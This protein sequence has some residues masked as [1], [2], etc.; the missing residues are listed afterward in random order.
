[1]GHDCA[2]V[3]YVADGFA[4]SI[5]FAQRADEPVLEQGST[6]YREENRLRDR[7]P[8][9]EVVSGDPY[10]LQYVDNLGLFGQD[11][12]RVNTMKDIGRE[13]MNRAGLVMHEHEDA[14]G[15]PMELLVMCFTPV[16][17]PYS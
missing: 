16:H 17:H 9:R 1:M 7:K 5:Y 14:E 2:T 15:K 12:K 8:F 11:N 10:H 4:W 3:L 13:S 6:L